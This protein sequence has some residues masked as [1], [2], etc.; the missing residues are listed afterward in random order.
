[1][2][3]RGD[4]YVGYHWYL[5]YLGYAGLQI[6]LPNGTILGAESKVFISDGNFHHLAVTV[7]RTA[8]TGWKFFV[9][10]KLVNIYDPPDV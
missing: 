4:H 10:G 9:D 6:G 2:D 5:S 7:T 8:K 3:K 1:M